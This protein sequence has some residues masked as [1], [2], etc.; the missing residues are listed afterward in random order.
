[1]RISI[2]KKSDSQNSSKENSKQH[3]LTKATNFELKL[4]CFEKT[5][6]RKKKSYSSIPTR[7][8]PLSPNLTES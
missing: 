4:K 6:G 8:G 3:P 2:L 7:H 1:M 5:L